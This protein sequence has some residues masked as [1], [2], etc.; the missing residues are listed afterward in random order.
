M[1]FPN[2]T[3][4]TRKDTTMTEA[5]EHDL[6]MMAQIEEQ[7]SRIAQQ[8]GCSVPRLTAINNN[9]VIM[10]NLS[11]YKGDYKQLMREAYIELSKHNSDSLNIS[12]KEEWLDENFFLEEANSNVSIIGIDFDGGANAIRVEDSIGN[13][14]NIHHQRLAELIE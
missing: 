3:T 4:T 12:I 11:I 7:V 9:N 8:Y 14:Y 10:A 1:T 5:N 13:E 6:K 2:I